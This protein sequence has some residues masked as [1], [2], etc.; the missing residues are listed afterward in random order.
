MPEEQVFEC[1]HNE[2]TVLRGGS[3]EPVLVLHDELGW[4]GWTSWCDLLADRRELIVPLQPGFGRSPRVPWIRSYRDLALF[5][6]RLVREMGL[7]P[8][9]IV[10]FSAGGYTAAEMAACSPQEVRSMTLVGPMGVKPEEG[11]IADFLAMPVGQHL[12]QT[13]AIPDAPDATRIYGGPM[14]TEQF[15]LFEEARAETARLGWEPFMFDPALPHH[16][17]AIGSLPVQLIRGDR[18]EIVPA[19][20]IDAYRRA[21]PEVHVEVLEGAG[22]RPETEMPDRFVSLLGDF[23]GEVGAPRLQAQTV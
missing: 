19:Q 15:E 20:C 5:Y 13:L 14:T 22:H 10:G 11:V 1:G 9:D 21:L 16:L 17:E 3:G 7:G 2:V 8:I 4:S 6:L 12:A 18:D 23:L